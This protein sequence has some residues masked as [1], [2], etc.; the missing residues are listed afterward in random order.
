MI[1]TLWILAI[2]VVLLLLGNFFTYTIQPIFIFRATKLKGDYQYRFMTPHKELWFDA[3]NGGKI[4]ALWFH[5]EGKQRPVIYYHHGNSGDLSKWGHL[6]VFFQ[7]IGFDLFIYDYRGFGKSKGHQS[8]ANFHSDAHY[9]YQFLQD[10]YQENQI[11]IYGRSMG[12]GPATKL[13]ADTNTALLVLET[14]YYS[15]RNLFTT[16]Y[17]FLPHQFF[18]F[19]FNFAVHEWI[20]KVKAP[21]RIIHGTNDWVVPLR[22]ANRLKG[23]LQKKDRFITVKDAAHKN[24]ADFDDY[25]LIITD[26]KQ[27]TTLK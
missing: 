27:I 21:V 14:P 13:A 4:N 18:R 6:G 2:L 3:P 12:S 20:D 10:H 17:P 19:R 16:Y 22:C 26:L 5:E 7:D 9:L 8:E 15:I 25:T 1:I 11:V 23:K 24:I